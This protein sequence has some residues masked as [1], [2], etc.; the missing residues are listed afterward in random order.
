MATR[1]TLKLKVDPDLRRGVEKLEFLNYIRCSVLKTLNQV[2]EDLLEM[3]EG[4][5]KVAEP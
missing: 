2:L 4:P 5:V 3:V 1:L